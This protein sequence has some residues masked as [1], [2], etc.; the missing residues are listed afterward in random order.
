MR[1]KS[2]AV[3]DLSSEKSRFPANLGRRAVI[4]RVIYVVGSP[5]DLRD[6]ARFGVAGW[7]SH[8]VAAEI[9]E[10]HDIFLQRDVEGVVQ[11]PPGCHVRS[12]SSIGELSTACLALTSNTAVI[13]MA[14]VGLRQFPT[15]RSM[16]VPLMKSRAV[17][18]TVSAGQRPLTPNESE[19]PSFVSRVRRHLHSLR[20]GKTTL[21]SL[22]RKASERLGASAILL[23]PPLIPSGL[24]PLDWIWV[25]TNT[26]SVDPL[27]IGEN[28]KIRYLHTWDYDLCLRASDI[29]C[30][31]RRMPVYLDAMGPLHPDFAILPYYQV[32]VDADDWFRTVDA[33]L[34]QIEE[35]LGE[36]VL[37]AAHPR[38]L[39]GSLENRYRGRDVLYGQTYSAIA[40]ASIVFFTD[41]TTTLGMTAILGKQAVA[42]QV[43]RL[44]DGHWLEMKEYIELMGLEVLEPGRIPAHWIP[45]PVNKSAY[46]SFLERY[47]KRPG[48]PDKPFWDEV[49]RDLLGG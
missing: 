23:Q 37:I 22:A 33:A 17:L 29:S 5:M 47:V 43:P 16:L 34:T 42:I 25:G 7:T 15:Y 2:P 31:G 26:E 1:P 46:S 32:E 38:A 6:F 8:K 13:I 11:P 40:G 18:T 9:W 35:C 20:S 41:P 36:P 3:L 48:T 19:P 21:A 4:Q 10:I 39:I 14:G 49:R 30:E 28:T 12:F 24:R 44:W 27:F 45:R